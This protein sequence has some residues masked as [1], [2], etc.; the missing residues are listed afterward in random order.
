[1]E[2]TEEKRR[3]TE[4]LQEIT[5]VY[6]RVLGDKLRGLYF[7]GSLAFGCFRWESSDIDFLAVVQGE[8]TH[9]EKRQ[10]LDWILSVREKCPPK[11]LDMSIVEEHCGRV[12]R[13]C[14]SHAVYVPLVGRAS[15]KSSGGSGRVL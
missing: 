6:Q 3:I 15:G 11:G 10:L 14:A 13:L 9:G 2:K 8:L 5:A 4:L 7:H 12:W 1:M